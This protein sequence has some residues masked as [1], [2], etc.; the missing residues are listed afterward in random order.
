MTATAVLP[1]VTA[2]VKRD[3]LLELSYTFQLVLRFATVAISV[4]MFFFLGRLFG[5]SDQ[6]S[7]FSGGYFE[8]ALLGLIVMGYSQACVMSFAQSIQRAQSSGTL[9][10]LLSTATR[11]PTLL[12]GSL[13]VPLVLASIDASFY[14]AVGALFGELTFAPGRLVLVAILLMLTLGTFA[15]IGVFSAA[16]IVLTKRGDPFSSLALQ[17]SNLLA[18]AVFPISVL[19]EAL[20]VLSR[21]VPAFYGLRGART[22]LLSGGGL[23]DVSVD[24]AALVGFN[25]VLL[26]L[27]T[28]LL[29][30]ALRVAR[31]TGT[32]GNR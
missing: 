31:V 20:Q 1:R 3:A 29:S 27:A 5:D 30:R 9:E 19:P 8:F 16:V 24:V 32:L 11:L 26:P 15:A 4:M 22:V 21:F 23:S 18:G 12:V 10:I 14:L 7:E 28:W 6:L 17:M 25:I 2:L 13:V